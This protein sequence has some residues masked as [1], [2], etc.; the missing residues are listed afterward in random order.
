MHRDSLTH[1]TDSALLS[2]LK[3]SLARERDA[4]A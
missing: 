1:L 4:L 3:T 2:G